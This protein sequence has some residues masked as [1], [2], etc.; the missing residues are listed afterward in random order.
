MLAATNAYHFPR[1]DFISGDA[2]AAISTPYKSF[3][4]FAEIHKIQKKAVQLP[5]Y[6]LAFTTWVYE[7]AILSLGFIIIGKPIHHKMSVRPA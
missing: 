3:A 4:R 2:L 5:K 6:K 1:L 7:T